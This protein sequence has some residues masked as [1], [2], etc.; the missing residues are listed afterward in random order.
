MPTVNLSEKHP[1]YSFQSTNWIL[2]RDAYRGQRQVKSK[3]TLYLPATSGQIADGMDNSNQPGYKAYEAYLMRAR[4]PN[5]VREAVQTAVGMMHSQP[6]KITLPPELEG[7]KSSKG[8]DLPQLLRRINEEQLITGRVGILADVATRSGEPLPY[9]ATYS[10]ERLINWDDGTVEGLVPQVLNFVVLDE[11]EYERNVLSFGWEIEEKYRVMYIGGLEENE[12]SGRYRVGVFDSREVVF[13]QAGLKTPSIRGRELDQIPFVIIN[14]CDLVSETD[15]PPLLDLGELC[16]TIY[17]GEA[18][19]RQN[20]FM[21]GQDTLVV[22]GGAQDED[23]QLRTGAGARIDV[24]I[25]GDAKYIGV[26]SDGLSEQREALNNDRTRA[27]SMG[28]QSLDTVSRERE[29]GTSLNIRIAARTADLNQIADTG[30]EG[31]ARILR[32]VAEWIGADPSLVSV[33]PNK[34]FGDAQLTGQTMV[35]Q[36]TARNLGYP[37]S[38]RSLHQNAYDKGLTKM[39]FEEEMEQAKREKGTI[40]APGEKGDRT[41]EQSG[42]GNP[43]GP[44]S[45]GSED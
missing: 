12:P 39:T 43:S 24:P 11:S 25:G 36:Q 34:E 4:F 10:A 9:L 26:E 7:I 18:D 2:M 16:Y 29:S 42:G 3:R 22:V 33:E 28:A 14:S 35:E 40:F 30:A 6:P 13:D 45:E 17:R 44:P 21:Q 37:I 27:G 23:E 32:I 1:Q 20:L 19:Y 31:L 41:P 15:E 5:F 38:A 8:E